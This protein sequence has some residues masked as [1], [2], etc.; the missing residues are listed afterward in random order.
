MYFIFLLLRLKFKMKTKSLL[1]QWT[2]TLSKM[3]GIVSRLG[4]YEIL[5]GEIFR[6]FDYYNHLLSL[7]HKGLDFLFGSRKWRSYV[8]R[9]VC[10][11]VCVSV[12]PLLK[13]RFKDFIH[14]CTMTEIENW[15]ARCWEKF[16][17]P[18]R[19]EKLILRN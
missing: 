2:T 12:T 17:F 16:L 13:K 8:I 5:I 3:M 19:G 4:K 7:V 1:V 9:L 10:M 15:Q 11:S 18:R 6:V 14:F